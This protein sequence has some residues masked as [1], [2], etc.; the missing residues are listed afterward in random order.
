MDEAWQESAFVAGCKGDPL[1]RCRTAAAPVGN[2]APGDR[3]AAGPLAPFQTGAALTPGAALLGHGLG[4]L[5]PVAPRP[6]VHT[7]APVEKLAA[8]ARAA[9]VREGVEGHRTLSYRPQP[10][11]DRAVARGRDAT[12]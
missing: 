10:V 9:A 12:L 7:R 5:A 8:L 4:R 11:P 6:A 1:R 3:R 2:H